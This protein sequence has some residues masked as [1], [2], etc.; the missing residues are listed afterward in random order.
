[1][2]SLD[3][4][5]YQLPQKLIAQKPMWKRDESKLL[6][7]ERDTGRVTH[8]KFSQIERFFLP[9]DIIVLNN[10]EVIPARL[11]GQKET[12]G[13]AEVLII[14]YADNRDKNQNKPGEFYC[15]CLIN[16]SKK[17][18]NNSTLKF[19]ENLLAVVLEYQQ[20]GIY[21]VKFT[22]PD[23]DFESVLY[24]VGKIPLPP[25]I[26]RK[27]NETNVTNDTNETGDDSKSYQTVYASQK[28]SAAAPTAGLHFTRELLDKLRKKGIKIVEITLH[29]GL[30]TF[31]PLRVSDIRDHDMH[32]ESFHVPQ[33]TAQ[34]INAAKKEGRRI[35][36]V[37]TT[38]VR[39]L[40]HF[41]D[42]RG[43]LSSG[44]GRCDLFIYPGYKFKVVD[45]I[46]TNFHLPKSTL[47]MLV[48]AFAGRKIIL[49][50]YDKA[51]KK[52][53]RFYSYGDA[54]LI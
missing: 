37:G 52:G 43:R 15:K 23:K 24:K 44:K 50:A 34:I 53:Y 10:T 48:S 1:M 47:L 6:F 13:K 39:V 22:F 35:I 31:M 45:S 49:S 3:D 54:M 46:I 40:E 16:A 30:G 18:K 25:Y 7:L 9:S 20:N 12:G 32:S 29:V 36:A 14:D 8:Y 2:Y 19:D 5:D 21:L 27:K 28:G 42:D 17:P 38:S 41:S 26:R 51:I 11:I 4:Y 33:K